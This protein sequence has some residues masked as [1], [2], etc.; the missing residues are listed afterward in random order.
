M[1]KTGSGNPNRQELLCESGVFKAG[2]S[3]YDKNVNVG[4][5]RCQREQRQGSACR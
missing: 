5:G 1:D 4:R 3:V 2:S